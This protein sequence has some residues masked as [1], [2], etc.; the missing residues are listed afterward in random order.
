MIFV[1]RLYL[2]KHIRLFSHFLN[3]IDGRVKLWHQEFGRFLQRK[4]LFIP[5]HGHNFFH[6]SLCCVG[7]VLPESVLER[8]FIRA[9]TL[10]IAIEELLLIHR[11]TCL[12]QNQICLRLE[13]LNARLGEKSVLSPLRCHTMSFEVLLSLNLNAVICYFCIFLRI[14]IISDQD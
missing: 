4:T 6:Q 8:G 7:Q 12:I 1:Q 3:V 9:L 10:N 2:L 5:Q 14:F 13:A 11:F